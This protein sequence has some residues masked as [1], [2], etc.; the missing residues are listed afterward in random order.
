MNTKAKRKRM[1]SCH[2]QIIN[3]NVLGAIVWLK[4][5]LMSC[6]R[7]YGIAMNHFLTYLTFPNGVSPKNSKVK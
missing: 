5:D 7:F 1:I 6:L 4:K 2:A 3:D